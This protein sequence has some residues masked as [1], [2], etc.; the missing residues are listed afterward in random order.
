MAGEDLEAAGFGFGDAV[1]VELL[2]SKNL[3]PDLSVNTNAV[4]VACQDEAL[5]PRAMTAAA[6]MRDAGLQVDIKWVGLL[7]PWVTVEIMVVK[8]DVRA[9]EKPTRHGR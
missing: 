4:L 6:A 8:A 5:R 3:L 7:E 1:I 2:R 9:L